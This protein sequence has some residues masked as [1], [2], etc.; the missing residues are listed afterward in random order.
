MVNFV[1]NVIA[2]FLAYGLQAAIFCAAALLIA[3]PGLGLLLTIRAV[4]RRVSPYEPPP[5]GEVPTLR[6]RLERL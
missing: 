3:I 5:W 1:G 4:W 6:D 2:W